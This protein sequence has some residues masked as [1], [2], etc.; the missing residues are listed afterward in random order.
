MGDIEFL[1]LLLVA[2]AV[3]VRL[4]DVVAVPYPIVLVVGG[5]AIGL[6]PWL[7]DLELEP[8]VVFLIFLPPLL[9]AAGWYS[10]PRMLKA[11]VRPL[12][13]LAVGLV[14]ATMVAV[15]VV[16]HAIVPGMSWEAAFLLGAIVGRPIR[17]PRRRPSRRLG[18]PERVRGLVEGEAMINDGTALVAYRVALV[19]AVEG[20]FSFGDALLEFA[21]SAAGG[22]AAGLAI[23]WLGYK[24]IEH[25]SD[26]TLSIFFSVLVAYASYIV[27]EELLHVSGVLATV[28]SGIYGGWNAHRLID[29]GTRLSAVAFWRVMT[30]GLETL[31]FVLLGL[32]APQLAEELE[33]AAL[34]GQA[35]VVALCVAG[36]RMAWVLLIPGGFGD[37]LQGTRGGRLGGHARRHL[38]RRCAR[39]QHGRAGAPADPPDHVRRDLRH[40]AGPG[41]HAAAAAARAQAAQRHGVLPGR[42]DR[43]A[44]DG[45][46]GARPARRARGGGRLRRRR[47]GGCGSSTGRASPSASPCWAAMSRRTGAAI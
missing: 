26:T 41:P 21:Y 30:F 34:A 29:A 19:A 27:G 7:P 15:A 43:A 13:L 47:S 6:V 1:L 5:L 20:T 36:V 39:R 37:T 8:D 28:T 40:P 45:A 14:L 25:Q 35:L 33:V 18:V 44:G 38:A 17:S 46:G 16:A 12:A 11:E 23:G 42:G 24:V 9:H 2:A 22:V 32:Q 4:A 31:L 3:L 10:D